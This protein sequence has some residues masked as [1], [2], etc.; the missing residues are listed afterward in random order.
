MEQ[1]SF[2]VLIVDDI[3]ENLQI[4]GNILN[5]NNIES[6]AALNGKQ[7]L[8]IVS[9]AK[10]D[11]IL[12]DI[13][14]PGMDGYEVCKKLKENPKTLNVPIIFLTAR[15]QTEDVIKGFEYGGVDYVVKPFNPIELLQRVNTHLKFKRS[16]EIIQNQMEQLES[17]N[18]TKDKFFSIIAHDLKNPFNALISVS[19]LLLNSGETFSLEENKRF[20]GMI[21]DSSKHTL[22]LLQ[23]LLTW[24]RSQTNKIPF[25]PT[26]FDI[27]ALINDVTT[28]HKFT[29]A[30]A[31][32]ITIQNEI[33]C[34]DNHQAIADREMIQTVFRNLLSNAIK[35]T[36][37]GGSIAIG[38][39]SY[40]KDEILFYVRDTGIGITQENLGKLFK[41][42]EG[43]STRG[44]DDERGTGLG[45]I[46]CKEFVEKNGGHI[47]VESENE[48]GSTFY[49]TL[50][51]S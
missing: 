35:F 46:L 28:F 50:K 33:L 27:K 31:K 22:N 14:M 39:K 2:T 44:T 11:L 8:K 17:L 15:S 6:Y 41:I 42:E 4:V 24:S 19:E 3:P 34:P 40:E 9:E 21:Y 25:N 29:L 30:D 48:M 49:F 43:F 20:I 12:L 13:S 47:W 5:E 26:S 23:N 45:L 38:C 37:K 32:Q 1:D 7:A 51:K 10:I 36:P 16:Q 18:A